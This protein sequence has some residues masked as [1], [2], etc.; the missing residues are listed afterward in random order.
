MR[1][2][3]EVAVARLAARRRAGAVLSD[4]VAAPAAEADAHHVAALAQLA[5]ELGDRHRALEAVV[6]NDNRRAGAARAAAELGR[7]R[8][9]RLAARRRHD[10][11]RRRRRR[12][13]RAAA[14][15]GR[16]EA[17]VARPNLGLAAAQHR[18]ERHA[19]GQRG[20][21]LH[22]E[23]VHAVALVM[24]SGCCVACV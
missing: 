11:A 14:A 21:L 12:R 9:R 8:R 3:A 4:A 1:T 17:R 10:S 13:P 6:E 7:G 16:Q 20:R 22:D 5:V 19:A 18:L 24:G 15:A 23:V 2:V